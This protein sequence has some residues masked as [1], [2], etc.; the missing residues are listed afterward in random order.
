MSIF[1]RSPGKPQETHGHGQFEMLPIKGWALVQEPS[2]TEIP[3]L[4]Q[5]MRTAM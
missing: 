5:G 3:I 1:A 2:L 4:V